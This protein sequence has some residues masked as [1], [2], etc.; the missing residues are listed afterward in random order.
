MKKLFYLI[1]ILI[2]AVSCKTESSDDIVVSNIYQAYLLS[3]NS[4]ENHTHACAQ[5]RDGGALGNDIVLNSPSAV[6]VD[7]EV[8]THQDLPFGLYYHYY[9]KYSGEKGEVSFVFKDKNNKEYTNVANLNSL[10]SIGLPPDLNEISVLDNFVL[11]W[12]GEPL[13]ANETVQLT[14]SDGNQA[15]AFS[16][17]TENSTSITVSK[18]DM[19]QFQVG[20]LDLVLSRYNSSNI[21]E[22]TGKEGSIMI[23]YTVEGSVKLVE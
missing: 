14:I 10:P 6:S 16:Q 4:S 11:T 7:G 18:I 3:F 13:G 12:V 20:N 21:Q 17:S 8:L 22:S 9:K 2:I 5:F 19:A 23:Q 1:F 15:E